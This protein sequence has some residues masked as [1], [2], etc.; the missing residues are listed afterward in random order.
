MHRSGKKAHTC[1]ITNPNL[2]GL[3]SAPYTSYSLLHPLSGNVFPPADAL[4]GSSPCQAPTPLPWD[5]CGWLDLLPLH[6]PLPPLAPESWSY[7]YPQAA[8]LFGSCEDEALAQP[9]LAQ[10]Q[11]HGSLTLQAEGLQSEFCAIEDD[12]AVG[13]VG[14]ETRIL[15]VPVKVTGILP[16]TNLLDFTDIH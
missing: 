8:K 11:G 13:V 14:A 3:S 6:I 15:L 7:L 10:P 9:C 5:G 1:L 4:A 12:K 2:L 16:W